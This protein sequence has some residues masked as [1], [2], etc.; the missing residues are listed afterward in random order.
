ML[1]CC[2]R[3]FTHP[4]ISKNDC[5]A[6]RRMQLPVGCF[7]AASSFLTPTCIA[8][9]HAAV[10]LVFCAAT[11]VR[12]LRSERSSRHARRQAAPAAFHVSKPRGLARAHT[13]HSTL[14]YCW[15]RALDR[16]RVAL[17]PDR[18]AVT[19]TLSSLS[20]PASSAAPSCPTPNTHLRGAC[21]ASESARRA[22]CLR[23]SSAPRAQRSAREGVRSPD[24]LFTHKRRRTSHGVIGAS[25]GCNRAVDCLCFATCAERVF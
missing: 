22:R 9:S 17:G 21:S 15:E 7:C 10:R 3:R 23:H 6:Q 19:P 25:R 13:A 14:P 16:Y 18:K 8:A 5:L 4:S 2:L 24:R 1:L 20:L 11:A 12:L